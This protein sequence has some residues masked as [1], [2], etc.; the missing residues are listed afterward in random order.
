MK[1]IFFF[2]WNL[3]SFM[4]TDF[5]CMENSG[6]GIP[7][8]VCWSNWPQCEDKCYVLGMSDILR[9]GNTSTNKKMKIW[10]LRSIL[11]LLIKIYGNSLQNI[12]EIS[13][14]TPGWQCPM[15]WFPINNCQGKWKWFRLSSFSCFPVKIV[16]IRF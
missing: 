7:T 6:W 8:R 2:W 1:E 13:I 12:L 9:S 3:D 4:K 16:L 10:T 11:K 5:K 14:Y 15:A